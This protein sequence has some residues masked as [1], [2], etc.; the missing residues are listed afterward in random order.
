VIFSICE[1]IGLLG[2]AA[3]DPEK[4][5]ARYGFVF[6]T[7]PPV[8]A[9]VYHAPTQDT[10]EVWIRGK[11]SHA[12]AAPEDG[13]SAIQ[14]AANA[15]SRMK[16]GRIDPDTTAN[17]GIIHGGTAANIITPEVYL[18]CEARSR[19]PSKLEAQRNHMIENFNVAA[20][21]LGGTV[22][23]KVVRNYEGYEIAQGS[24]VLQ[25]A[26]QA[27]QRVGIEFILRV[28]GGGSDAN[29]FNQREIPAV[30]AGC[31]MQKVH[32]H[33]EFVLISDMVRS[34]NLVKA[35]VG[36]AAEARL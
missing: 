10:F 8:G 4:I 16:L 33:D 25:I 12:G 2:A 23:Y 5:K 29:I 32:T 14:I 13:V 35:I 31:G 17:V 30:V 27:A 20:A 1:E 24:P 34:V 11:A 26:K 28:T 36:S 9:F 21:E 15:V 19:V 22:E 3:L 7:G 18:K 6:D